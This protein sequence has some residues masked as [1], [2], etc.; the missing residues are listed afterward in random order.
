MLLKNKSKSKEKS[1]DHLTFTE[2]GLFIEYNNKE[3]DEL[4]FSQ[5]NKSYIKKY[6]VCFAYKSL[7]VMLSGIL[8]L[9]LTSYPIFFIPIT[10]VFTLLFVKINNFRWYELKII[11]LDGLS[12][13]KRF[14]V[15]SKQ[16]YI[17]LVNII[18]REIFIHRVEQEY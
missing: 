16:L 7:F 8:S 3:F 6:K 17:A 10:G 11:G 9:S 1:F 13:N 5:L 2:K 15:K 18:K 14:D 12:Y 4:I